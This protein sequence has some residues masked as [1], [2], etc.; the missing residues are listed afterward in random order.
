ML[1][2]LVDVRS[3]I[4]AFSSYGLIFGVLR[5]VELVW[6]RAKPPLGFVFCGY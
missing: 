6:T 5:I 1:V 3:K 4:A 2:K